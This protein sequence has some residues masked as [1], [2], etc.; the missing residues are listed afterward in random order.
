MRYQLA[1]KAVKYLLADGM[2]D[3]QRVR[4]GTSVV[5]AR[6][7]P[8]SRDISLLISRLLDLK[9]PEVMGLASALPR[10]TKPK[11]LHGVT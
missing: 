8:F 2:L 4:G 10:L 5:P 3:V 6:D 11:S 9:Y 1:L 7:N